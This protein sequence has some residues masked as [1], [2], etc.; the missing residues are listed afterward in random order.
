MKSKHL[1]FLGVLLALV[2]LTVHAQHRG[3]KG[4]GPIVSTV[5]EAHELRDNSPVTLQGKIERFLGF[6]NRYLFS[7]DTGSI[8]LIISDRRWNDL[9]VDEND[10]VEITGIIDSDGSMVGGRYIS[11][12]AMR[13]V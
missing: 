7:D 6:G 4:P 12:L 1:V 3:Y 2:S 5:A 9:S 11:V 13:K 8:T 10:V